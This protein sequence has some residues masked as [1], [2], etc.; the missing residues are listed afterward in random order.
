MVS[1]SA[2]LL[3]DDAPALLIMSFKAFVP[4][5][6]PKP[7]IIL[8]VV[9]S[10]RVQLTFFW[11]KVALQVAAASCAVVMKFKPFTVTTLLM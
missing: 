8:N 3:G 6:V 10:N 4:N 2:W 1:D 7:I 9:E 5:G 11:P